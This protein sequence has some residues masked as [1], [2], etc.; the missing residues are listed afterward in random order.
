LK[1]VKE[2]MNQTMRER[3]SIPKIPDIFVADMLR[4]VSEKYNAP[5]C[6]SL[7]VKVAHCRTRES[8]IALW[9]FAR[10]TV[11]RESLAKEYKEAPEVSFD[12]WQEVNAFLVQGVKRNLNTGQIVSAS[13]DERERSMIEYG[14]SAEL[15]D[16]LS[17]FD[18]VIFVNDDNML[19][20]IE[21]GEVFP[22][23]GPLTHECIH[24]IEVRT[25]QHLISGFDHK[26]Y[27]DTVSLAVLEEFITRI[28][29]EEFMRRYLP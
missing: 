24:I 9:S 15:A 29:R 7:K 5:Q 21:A 11:D 18:A 23:H 8:W 20:A 26:Q 28:G 22:L 3:F 4:H 27:H 2:G 14:V 6:A 17:Q 25:D 13:E 1:E 10:D 16:T 19:E 12:S